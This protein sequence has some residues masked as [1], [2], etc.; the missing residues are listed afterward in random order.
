MTP[1]DLLAL[2]TPTEIAVV[3]CGQPDLINFYTEATSCTFPIYADPTK[4]LY[5][6]LGMARTLN[7]GHNTPDYMQKPL[8]RVMLASVYQG[9]SQGT[10]AFKGGDYYQVG[11][12][13][14][15]E[16][17]EATWCHRMTN[18]RDHA[19]V[20][21]LRGVL[22]L[23]EK[24]APLKKRWSLSNGSVRR[25]LS[26]RRQSWRKR[27]SSRSRSGERKRTENGRSGDDSIREEEEKENFVGRPSGVSDKS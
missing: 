21:E 22:G 15:F 2:P 17:D 11:G 16:N 5:N 10:K 12:E 7:L 26:L 23:D 3:G 4:R 24:R 9:L 8:I 1:Q 18:T 6:E 20:P 14:L 19:E 27:S 13:F 25:S